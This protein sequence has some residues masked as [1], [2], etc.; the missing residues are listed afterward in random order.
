MNAPIKNRKAYHNYEIIEKVEAGIMLSGAEVKSVREAKVNLSEA[1][2]QF[3][4][5][6][7]FLNNMHITPYDRQGLYAPDPLRKRKLLLHKKEIAYLSA[8]VN[9][10]KLT[11]IP[12]SLYFRKNWVKVEIG[13]CRGL[14]KYDKRQ[15]VAEQDS[16]RQIAQLRKISRNV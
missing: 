12:L 8:Q 14:K 15:K 7:L 16:R 11:L 5:D 3:R 1:F 6:E 9:R 4:E 13:L 10:K 2:A